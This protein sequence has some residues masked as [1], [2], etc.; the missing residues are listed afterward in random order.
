M[1]N[2]MGMDVLQSL[3]DDA[4]LP[5]IKVIVPSAQRT[6]FPE[7]WIEVKDKARVPWIENKKTRQQMGREQHIDIALSSKFIPDVMAEFERNLRYHIQNG[8][9]H[10]K[11]MEDY[12]FVV[13]AK[14]YKNQIFA[15]NLG[16]LFDEGYEKVRALFYNM[17]IYSSPLILMGKRSIPISFLWISD[18]SQAWVEP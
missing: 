8:H 13:S 15:E 18:S 12:R 17:L 5:A 1:A 16:D 2:V 6:S 3:M 4:L 11:K 10:L 7:L 9:P 14:N